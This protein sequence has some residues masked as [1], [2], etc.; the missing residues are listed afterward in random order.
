MGPQAGAAVGSAV[1]LMAR[2]AAEGTALK[3]AAGSAL[4]YRHR[5]ATIPATRP[6]RSPR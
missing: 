3:S 1:T 6:V 4:P 2:G 5:A